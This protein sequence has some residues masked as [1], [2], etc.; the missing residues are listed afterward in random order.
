MEEEHHVPL[1]QQEHA[2][3]LYVEHPW[4]QFKL[5]LQEE[6]GVEGVGPDINQ[7]FLPFFFFLVAEL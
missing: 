3:P 4:T 2:R 5:C 1:S 7:H 6:L